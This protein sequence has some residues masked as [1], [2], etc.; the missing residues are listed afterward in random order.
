M[1]EYGGIHSVSVGKTPRELHVWQ[2]SKTVWVTMGE[3]MGE[4]LGGEGRSENAAIK[5][6]RDRA[7]RKRREGE[8]VSDDDLGF[9]VVKELGAHDEV[10]VAVRSHRVPKCS[11]APSK[12]VGASYGR[13]ENQA[14]LISVI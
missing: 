4:W 9:K 2:Q 14:F 1:I 6:W 12:A 10:H 8:A 7:D 11:C 3:Y 13:V 5:Y